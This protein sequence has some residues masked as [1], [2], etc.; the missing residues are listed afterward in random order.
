MENREEEIVV[1]DEG[2]EDRPSIWS[3][4]M[5]ALIPYRW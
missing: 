2:I 4:C 3:C 5:G 1:L